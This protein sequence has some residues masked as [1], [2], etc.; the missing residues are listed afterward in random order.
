[1]TRSMMDIIGSFDG[2]MGSAASIKNESKTVNRRKRNLTLNTT[3][4]VP[5]TQNNSNAK[6]NS[7]FYNLTVKP[8][9]IMIDSTKHGTRP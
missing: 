5:Q 2:Q 8:I 1:M 3:S 9:N 6:P 7:P 4:L